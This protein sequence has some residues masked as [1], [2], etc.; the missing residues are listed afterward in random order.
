MEHRIWMLASIAALSWLFSAPALDVSTLS[1]A[2]AQTTTVKCV[3]RAPDLSPPGTVLPPAAPRQ[4]SSGPEISQACPPG[5]VP[6]V[7]PATRNFPK[8]N[9]LLGMSNAPTQ[10][11]KGESVRKNL[12]PFDQVYWKREGLTAKPASEATNNASHTQ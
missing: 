8:G 9:P 1:E 7:P 11:A 12:R 10:G 6:V 2:N 3:K 5:E 4:T